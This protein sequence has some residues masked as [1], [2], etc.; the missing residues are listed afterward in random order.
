MKT[1]FYISISIC[2]AFFISSCGKKD[3]TNTTN[4]N[5][6]PVF[7][8]LQ[9]ATL[10]IN[11]TVNQ[12][13]TDTS[14]QTA[15]NTYY[16]QY[17]DAAEKGCS[18]DF[19][20]TQIPAEGSFAITPNFTEILPGSKKV[21]VQFFINGNSFQGQ[22]GVVKITGAGSAAV[23]EYCKVVFKNSFGESYICSFKSNLP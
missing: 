18:F 3:K 4:T 1:A 2:L 20:G 17:Q 12:I 13:T 6:A 16:L 5:T 21:Y 7:C 23:I 19:E 11:D 15:N 14:F 10:V 9:M 8:S 22:S